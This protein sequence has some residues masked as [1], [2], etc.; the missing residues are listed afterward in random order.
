M[1]LGVE[2]QAIL[3]PNPTLHEYDADLEAVIHGGD[4]GTSGRMHWRQPRRW[5]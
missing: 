1:N 5:R 3:C 2:R 4:R